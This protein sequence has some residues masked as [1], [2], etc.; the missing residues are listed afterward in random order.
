MEYFSFSCPAGSVFVIFSVILNSMFRY[1][2][3]GSNGT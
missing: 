1:I 2:L 3:A